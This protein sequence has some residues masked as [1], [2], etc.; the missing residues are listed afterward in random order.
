M[1]K[2]VLLDVSPFGDRSEVVLPGPFPPRKPLLPTALQFLQ[3]PYRNHT[4]YRTSYR[5]Q[6][7]ALVAFSFLAPPTGFEPAISSMKNWRPK[8]LDDGGKNPFILVR[9]GRFEL[10]VGTS[11]NSPSNCR[12]CRCATLAA[13]SLYQLGLRLRTKE[14]GFLWPKASPFAFG[15]TDGT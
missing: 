11:P 15:R 9:A 2:R 10:P 12:V 7:G 3:C 4:I 5:F 14:R 6:R 13:P 1:L 8:P